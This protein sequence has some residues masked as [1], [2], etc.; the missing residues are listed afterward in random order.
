MT[1]LMS[2]LSVEAIRIA[3]I[4]IIAIAIKHIIAITLIHII[5][6]TISMTNISN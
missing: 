3:I 4:A 1:Y 6:A 2:P 5:I